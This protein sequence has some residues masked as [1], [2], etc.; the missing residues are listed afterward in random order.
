[1]KIN[2]YRCTREHMCNCSLCLPH[3]V[4]V[5]VLGEM[6]LPCIECPVCAFVC[7]CVCVFT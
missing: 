4:K 2:T 6:Q 1:M 7:V 5:I 3:I